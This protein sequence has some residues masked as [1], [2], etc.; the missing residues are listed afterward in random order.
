MSLFGSIDLYREQKKRNRIRPWSI[1]LM[2][3]ASIRSQHINW[4]QCRIEYRNGGIL[5][6]ANH[7]TRPINHLVF[8]LNR[9]EREKRRESADNDT[10][11]HFDSVNSLIAFVDCNFYCCHSFRDVIVRLCAESTFHHFGPHRPLEL[12]YQ[13][14]SSR[15]CD[16]IVCCVFMFRIEL[17]TIVREN[18]QCRSVDG[19]CERKSLNLMRLKIKF[20]LNWHR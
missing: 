3:S 9:A 10:I 20:V 15:P 11:W 13:N 14:I 5:L 18:K 17:K 19:E 8:V 12:G 16:S 4:I 6:F 1:R 7:W 2:L